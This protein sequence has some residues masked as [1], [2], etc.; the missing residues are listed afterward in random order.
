MLTS[1]SEIARNNQLILIVYYCMVVLVLHVLDLSLLQILFAGT[2]SSSAL[3]IFSAILRSL[4][5]LVLC[6]YY[7][8][9]VLPFIK[10]ST[11]ITSTPTPITFNLVK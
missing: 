8:Y 10:Y 1:K 7:Y 5:L 2:G 6:C 11:I 3:C 4:F 9:F